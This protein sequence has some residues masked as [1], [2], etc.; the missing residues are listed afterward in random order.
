MANDFEKFKEIRR[1][2]A[3]V[4]PEWIADYEETG[5]MWNDPY[6]MNWE[7]SPIEQLVWGD[8]R[9]LAVPFYPQMPVLNYFIDFGNPF[10]KIGIECDGK[11]FHDKERD[12]ARDKRLAEAGWMIFRIEGHE[13]VREVDLHS[14]EYDC[15][16]LTE[17]DAV[18]RAK[19]FASTSEGIVKAIKLAYFNDDPDAVHDWRATAT[20]ANH[21]TTPENWTHRRRIVPKPSGPVHIADLLAE[22]GLTMQ[23]RMNRR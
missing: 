20:L 23:R 19:Y 6:L 22:Y 16:R 8:I 17:R 13:C 2:Y 3:A 10:L 4:L 14:R 15:D 7:F 9:H 21:R 11:E 18:D 12:A 1:L 5:N